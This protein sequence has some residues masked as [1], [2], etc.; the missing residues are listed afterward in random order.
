MGYNSNPQKVQLA[1]ATMRDG[2]QKI[3]YVTKVKS[4]L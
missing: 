4:E 1:L 2:L 3:G